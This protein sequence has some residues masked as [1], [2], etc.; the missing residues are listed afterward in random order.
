MSNEERRKKRNSKEQRKN[1]LLLD[2]ELSE[3]PKLLKELL[4]NPKAVFERLGVDENALRCPEEIHKAYERGTRAAKEVERLGKTPLEEAL[5]RIKDVARLK[6]GDDFRVDKVP[7]GLR[8]LV[9]VPEAPYRQEMAWTATAT[10]E[11]TFG[12]GCHGDTDG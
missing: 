9:K 5:P 8:F 10:F 7:F 12:P 4:D 1:H 6:L 3:N 2:S 11:C